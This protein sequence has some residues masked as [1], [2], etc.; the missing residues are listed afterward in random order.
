MNLDILWSQKHTRWSTFD[1]RNYAIYRNKILKVYI[2]SISHLDSSTPLERP[3]Q[4][5]AQHLS[6]PHIISNT[7]HPLPE[8]ELRRNQNLQNYTQT[9]RKT[10]T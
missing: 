3:S 7:L 10:C 4:T 9:R 2:Y 6:Q 5:H 1:Y 8:S